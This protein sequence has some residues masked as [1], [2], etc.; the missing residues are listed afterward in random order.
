MKNKVIVS[1]VTLNLLFS[2]VLGVVA[3]DLNFKIKEQ[4]KTNTAIYNT[5]EAQD[6]VNKSVE[7]I[8]GMIVSK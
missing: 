8:L 7:K 6:K 4:A 5:L 2:A 3:F 1:L